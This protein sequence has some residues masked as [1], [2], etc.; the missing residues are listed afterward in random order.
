MEIRGVSWNVNGTRKFLSNLA[1]VAFLSAFTVVFLQETFETEFQPATEHLFL[2]GFTERHIFASRGP[3]GRGS[4][5]LKTFIDSRQFSSG[6]IR[7]IPTVH[8]NFL[9]VRWRPQEMD[10]GVLFLN[11][12]VPRHDPSGIFWLRMEGGYL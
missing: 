4:G 9:A 8:D 2:R 7:R 5:G 12:Y 6:S 10:I 3:R 11:V 1:V